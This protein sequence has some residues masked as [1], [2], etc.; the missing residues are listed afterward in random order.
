MKV[1]TSVSRLVYKNNILN[2]DIREF[3]DKKNISNFYCYKSEILEIDEEEIVNSY[4]NAFPRPC[5][6]DEPGYWY[7][8][9]LYD[10]IKNLTRFVGGDKQDMNYEIV[11]PGYPWDI[12]WTDRIFETVDEFHKW[13]LVEGKNNI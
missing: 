10:K 11:E 6:T 1:K 3:M 7:A 4:L 12:P 8:N 9:E 5:S 13:M 2:D